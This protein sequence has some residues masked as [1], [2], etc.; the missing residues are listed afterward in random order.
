MRQQ[1][2]LVLRLDFARVGQELLAVDDRQPF[3]LQRE[4]DRRLDDVDADRLLVQAALFELDLD[5][6]G[7]VLGAAHLGR[8]RAAHQR[9]AGA[10]ALPQPVAIELMVLGRRPEVPQDRLVILRQQGE[11]ADL[12]LG[13]G[14]DVRRG[15]VPDVVHVEAE[16]RAHLRLRQQRLD[17]VQPLPAE[18]IEV[19]APLPIDRHRSVGL[20]CHGLSPILRNH[21]PQSFIARSTTCRSVGTVASSSVGENGIGT[22]I[23]ASRVTGASR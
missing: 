22:C 14:A 10:R 8:H 4:E 16:H 7:H 13:P 17:P 21:L 3:L 2:D 6:A 12:V 15:D 1:R 18:A 9:D 23:A 5:L 19:D 11:A 20:D